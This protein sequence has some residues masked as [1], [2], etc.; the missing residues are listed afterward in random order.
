MLPMFRGSGRRS[1]LNA[2]VTGFVD[3]EG[4]FNVSVKKQSTARF[5]WVIDPSFTVT[6]QAENGEVLELI[7]TALTC[8]RIIPKPGQ[9]NL[10]VFVVDNRRQLAEKVVPFFDKHQL[11]I[12]RK[13]FEAF[14]AI[15]AKLENKEHS[16]KEGLTELIRMAT[17]IHH[18]K[19]KRK[20]TEEILT[21]LKQ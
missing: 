9:P 10:L 4:S 16:T 18:S 3:G 17:S 1:K 7:K 19:G 12:K 2:Y 11:L 6:Q 13:D 8:G 21:S 15:V 5:G 20:Y 14:R